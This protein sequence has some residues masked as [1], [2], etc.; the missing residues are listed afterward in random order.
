MIRLRY[1]NLEVQ[2]LLSNQPHYIIRLKETEISFSNILCG[3]EGKEIK[4]ILRDH[5]RPEDLSFFFEFSRQFQGLNL[6]ELEEKGK[7]KKKNKTE[8]EE[9]GSRV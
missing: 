6:I 1:E 5:Y 9:T 8:R 3:S 7:M 2:L 4:T